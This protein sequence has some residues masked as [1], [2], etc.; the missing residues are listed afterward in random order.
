[1]WVDVFL[2]NAREILELV[3]GFDARLAAFRAAIE[4]GDGAKI[5]ALIEEARAAR[6]A[7]LS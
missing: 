5:A 6:A 4:A 1:M 2:E 3:R 7:V